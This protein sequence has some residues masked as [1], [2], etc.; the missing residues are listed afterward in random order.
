M[1][2]DSLG[3]LE[4]FI[5]ALPAG[6][7]GSRPRFQM[8]AASAQDPDALHGLGTYGFIRGATA[9]LVGASK[10]VGR[11][12]ED[13]GYLMEETILAATS[14]GLGTCWLGGSFKRSSF[15]RRISIQPTEEIP[16]VTA[17]GLMLNEE[18]ARNGLIRQQVGAHQRRSWERMF[19]EDDFAHPLT[20]TRAEDYA[21]PLEM[22]RLGPSASNKQPW[23]VVRK[24]S[25]WHFYLRRTQGYHQGA[26]NQALKIA[27]L[28]RIDIGI[29]MCHF[30]LTARELGLAGEWIEAQ[31]EMEIPFPLVKYV[32]TWRERSA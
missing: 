6:P 23:Q 8:L 24:G 27:D 29:A 3:I 17:M 13:L 31:P 25:D 18:E 5:C 20:R 16:A 19:W 30:E 14:L 2:V 1:P 32:V 4:A 11:Y 7:F 22:V 10:P 15:G 9:F 28:Q 21:L 26:V 12:L